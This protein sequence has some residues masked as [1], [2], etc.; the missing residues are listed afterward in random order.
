MK[1]GEELVSIVMPSFN[2]SRFI[3]KSIDSVLSQNY[4]HIELL[5]CDG[6]SNDKTQTI[7]EEYSKKDPRIQWWSKPDKGPSHA[8]NN[9]IRKARGTIIGWLNS[10]D[11]Y[12]ENAFSAVLAEFARNPETIMVYGQGQHVDVN[13]IPLGPYPTLPPSIGIKAFANGCFICQPTAFFRRSLF[14]MLGPLNESLSTAFDYEYWL[15]AFYAFPTRI[16]FVDKLL[17]SSRLHDN[18]ITKRQRRNVALEGMML[19]AKYFKFSR[20]HWITTYFEEISRLSIEEHGL[21]N[22]NDHFIDT[23]EMAATYLCE[24]DVQR[25]RTSLGV[26]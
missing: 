18:C 19:C 5:V 1:Q 17:A 20:T 3:G 15:R 22:V 14:T 24:E 11:I 13:E 12:A 9:A 8:L 25:L 10:D 16:G 21:T 26:K 23:L 7:L 2:Q 6:G 4:K